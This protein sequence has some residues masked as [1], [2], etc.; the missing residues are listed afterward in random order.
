MYNKLV[1]CGSHAEMYQTRRCSSLKCS[2]VLGFIL[3]VDQ[4][5]FTPTYMVLDCS[6]SSVK[7]IG[8]EIVHL[9]CQL[10]VQS[11]QVYKIWSAQTC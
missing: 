8:N 5:A 2:Y 9:H 11:C 10:A 7:V 4:T 1:I 6:Q 3:L